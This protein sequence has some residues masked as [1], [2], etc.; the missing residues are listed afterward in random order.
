MIC[1]HGESSM[2]KDQFFVIVLADEINVQCS[3]RFICFQRR[4]RTAIR[5]AI[6][7][8]LDYISSGGWQR[9]YWNS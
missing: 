3:L 2:Q 5:L 8:G 4:K 9:P 1:Q 7:V 6:I